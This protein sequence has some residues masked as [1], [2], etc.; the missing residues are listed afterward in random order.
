[1]NL[2]I[3]REAGYQEAIVGLSLSHGITFERAKEVAVKL[4]PKDGGH[5][6]VLEAITV[7]L[8]VT[9]PR[10]W[11]Q[12][13]DTYRLSSK[14]SGSTMHTIQKK[15]LEQYDFEAPIYPP[16][17]LHLNALVSA[18]MES[19]SVEDLVRLKNELPEGFL[20]RRIWVINYKCLRNILL[21]RTTHRLPQWKAFCAHIREYSL[22]PELLS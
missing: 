8:D 11:W 16:T 7:W 4:A 9:A 18:Y 3:M 19:K 13:A 15:H 22:Y 5:N 12:E 1:M 6:K 14:Q 2:I 21:Q 17:L 20:Q 10:Y